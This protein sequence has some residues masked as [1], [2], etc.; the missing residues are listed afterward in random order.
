MTRLARRLALQL[1]TA[2]LLIT[3]PCQAQAQT[4]PPKG[5][6]GARGISTA[7]SSAPAKPAG[8]A[9]TRVRIVLDA[10]FLPSSVD[11]SSVS[12][13][14]AYAEQ[15]TIRSSYEA[16]AGFGPGGALQVSVYRGFGVLVGYS[17]ASRDVLWEQ[18][19]TRC[20]AG[21]VEV[22]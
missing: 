12:T 15:A 5:K 14:T 7:A 8:P 19:D 9:E 2:A 11:Y 17:H 6:P 1:L 4:P 22:R 16:G 20:T 3:L 10:V 21:I 13:P 18:P